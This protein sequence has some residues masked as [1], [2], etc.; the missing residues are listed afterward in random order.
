M[1]SRKAL[2]LMSSAVLY[3]IV[4][5]YGPKWMAYVACGITLHAVAVVLPMIAWDT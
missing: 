3:I 2:L 5:V 1:S 4:I